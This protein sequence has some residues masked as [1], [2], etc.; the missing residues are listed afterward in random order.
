MTSLIRKVPKVEVGR[1]N[2]EILRDSLESV[3]VTSG[4]NTVRKLSMADTPKLEI[5]KGTTSLLD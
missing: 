1:S 3:H 5:E 2:L 4:L